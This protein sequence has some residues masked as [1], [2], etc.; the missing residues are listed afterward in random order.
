MRGPSVAW[1]GEGSRIVRHN[2]PVGRRIRWH[3]RRRVGIQEIGRTVGR[4]REL[5]EEYMSGA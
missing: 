2:V 3:S 1:T 5:I 4:L